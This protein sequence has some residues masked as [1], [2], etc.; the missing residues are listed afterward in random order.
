MGDGFAFHSASLR[1]KTLRQREGS[2][3]RACMPHGR[4]QV[5]GH[6]V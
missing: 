2:A 1:Q 6:D 4:S 3:G 5:R